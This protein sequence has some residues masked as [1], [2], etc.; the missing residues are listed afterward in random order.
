[1]KI[2]P[3]EIRKKKQELG[4]VSMNPS[5]GYADEGDDAL[6]AEMQQQAAESEEADHAQKTRFDQ[7]AGTTTQNQ[8][9]Y[10][11]RRP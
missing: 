3:E 10:G 1:M 11:G 9:R 8:Y 7:S 5:H 6:V 4:Q 2:T